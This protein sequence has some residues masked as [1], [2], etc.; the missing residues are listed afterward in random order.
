MR[1]TLLSLR[2]TSLLSR[3]TWFVAKFSSNQFD[4]VHTVPWSINISDAWIF[5][6]AFNVYIAIAC[7]YIVRIRRSSK[8]DYYDVLCGGRL[9]FHDE[10][11]IYSNSSHILL[12]LYSCVLII[13]TRYITFA[14]VKWLFDYI[15]FVLLEDC[16]IRFFWLER[17]FSTSTFYELSASDIEFPWRCLGTDEPV[18]NI[19]KLCAAKTKFDDD[20]ISNELA[21]FIVR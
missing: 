5:L 21:N 15:R 13:Y 18:N 11:L 7:T 9:M 6:E 2:F 10:T 17:Y 3:S 16:R 12:I 8:R 20:T 19:K 1:L 4:T 14:N